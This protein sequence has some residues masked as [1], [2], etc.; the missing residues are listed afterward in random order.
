MQN[1]HRRSECNEVICKHVIEYKVLRLRSK[2][3]I[4]L[5]DNVTLTNA[6]VYPVKKEKEFFRTVG[7][8][9]ER[10]YLERNFFRK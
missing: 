9:K 4:N 1:S 6:K 5:T 10:K 2:L 3:S 8:I 7:G